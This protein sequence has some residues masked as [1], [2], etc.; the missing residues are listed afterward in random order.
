MNNN[1]AQHEMFL[2]N[3]TRIP[4]SAL[5]RDKYPTNFW[6]WF[7]T[8]EAQAIYSEFET[9]ALEVA[10]HRKH[11]SARTIVEVLR[12]DSLL[13]DGG[14]EYK[15][16]NNWIPGLARLFMHNWSDTYP[17]FFAIKDYQ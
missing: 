9:R 15:I 14:D 10:R 2:P 5:E 6:H 13:R 17:G 7:K 16:S 1:A 8:F 11:Y 12:W 3:F 4:D